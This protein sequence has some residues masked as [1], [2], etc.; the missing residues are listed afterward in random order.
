MDTSKIL[1]VTKA[2][3]MNSEPGVKTPQLFENSGEPD[4]IAI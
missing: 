3:G 2:T 1:M 4:V